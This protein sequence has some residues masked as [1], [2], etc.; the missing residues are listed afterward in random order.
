MQVKKIKE[1]I[2]Y[3]P[4]AGW[5]STISREQGST[6]HNSATCQNV[7]LFLLFSFTLYMI[8]HGLEYPFGHLKSPVPLLSPPMHLQLL[9]QQGSTKSRK[10]LGSL[11]ATQLNQKRFYIMNIVFST[12]PQPRFILG[13]V[14]NSNFTLAKIITQGKNLFNLSMKMVV[15]K[16]ILHC[17]KNQ[18]PKAAVEGHGDGIR[19]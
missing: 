6:T 15:E 12:N 5:S 4:W 14:K 19:V 13:I 16:L 18:S 10:H 3:F 2:Y 1:L 7:F 11:Q 17:G 9:H 8:S